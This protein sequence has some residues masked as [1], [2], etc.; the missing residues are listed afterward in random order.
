MAV[1]LFTINETG[2]AGAAGSEKFV[3][4]FISMADPTGIGGTFTQGGIYIPYMGTL[5]TCTS[6]IGTNSGNCSGWGSASIIAWANGLYYDPRFGTPFVPP[7]GDHHRTGYRMMMQPSFSAGQWNSGF[8]QLA[9]TFPFF[10]EIGQMGAGG[11]IA[12]ALADSSFQSG[13][14][15]ILNFLDGH[16][17]P[18]T[19][20]KF[21]RYWPHERA[22]W[23]DTLMVKYTAGGGT[24]DLDMFSQSLRSSTGFAR[25]ATLLRWRAMSNLD[26][27]FS[28]SPGQNSDGCGASKWCE[29]YV[30][31]DTAG[32]THLFVI[33]NA[34]ANT[35]TADG[36][37]VEI[38]QS[39]RVDT[40][41]AMGGNVVIKNMA[42][43]N[44]EKL[45]FVIDD[46]LSQYSTEAGTPGDFEQQLLSQFRVVSGPN[47][48]SEEGADPYA[49]VIC[50]TRGALY[51][52][53]DCTAASAAGDGAIDAD[54]HV[55]AIVYVPNNSLELGESPLTRFGLDMSPRRLGNTLYPQGYVDTLAPDT[56]QDPNAYVECTTGAAT[57]PVHPTS[58]CESD[59][60]L[61]G[62]YGTVDDGTIYYKEA[63]ENGLR[64]WIRETNG[65]AFSFLGADTD[66]AHDGVS[67]ANFGLTELVQQIEPTQGVLISCLG[68]SPHNLPLQ[69]D[70]VTYTFTWPGLPTVTPIL[71][72]PTTGDTVINVVP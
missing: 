71:H 33:K 56:T 63:I 54:G 18:L 59:P 43:S 3:P 38:T 23:V 41:G 44:L 26:G 16:G 21:P 42:L 27:A 70:T 65:H 48:H 53:D 9:Q 28:A 57:Q 39:S 1:N 31:E 24:T 62:M 11:D 52:E 15:G 49:W 25:N 32:N 4:T 46:R 72:P 13:L 55:F 67:P 60:G 19:T 61:D 40:M 66:G 7:S 2:G 20:G 47:V 5:T 35:D 29:F 45:P 36:T 8:A 12:L 6:L 50:G 14:V 68:C 30:T 34:D 58:L 37:P 22:A 17:E 69:Q 10:P 64:G 51:G